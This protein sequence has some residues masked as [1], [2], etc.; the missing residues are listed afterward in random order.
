MTPK[1]YDTYNMT[2]CK[3]CRTTNEHFKILAV[4]EVLVHVQYSNVRSKQREKEGVVDQRSISTQT[5]GTHMQLVI[6]NK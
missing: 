5:I 6:T 2:L 4:G 1:W 3:L